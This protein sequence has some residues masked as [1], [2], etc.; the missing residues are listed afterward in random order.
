MARKWKLNFISTIGLWVS[1]FPLKMS[2]ENNEERKLSFTHDIVT[3]STKGCNM[4]NDCPLKM[5]MTVKCKQEHL[6][7]FP[8]FSL[9]KLPH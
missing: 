2:K 3:P 7:L 9:F 4:F 8:A 1:D 6:H 5:N